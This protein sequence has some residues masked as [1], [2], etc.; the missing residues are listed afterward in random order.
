[1]LSQKY[2]NYVTKLIRFVRNFE[3]KFDDF[4]YLAIL[5]LMFQKR[6]FYEPV[7]YVKHQ[8]KTDS[9]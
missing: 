8:L 6:P 5:R 9:N 4:S 3:Q 1:M 2:A 7:L